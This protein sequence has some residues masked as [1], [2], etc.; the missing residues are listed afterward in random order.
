M[1]R[2]QLFSIDFVI[3]VA[4]IAA[5][6]GLLMQSHEFAFR[7]Q[8]LLADAQ[9]NAAQS[10]AD[11]VVAGVELSAAPDYCTSFSNGSTDC[12]GFSCPKN[13]FVGKRLVLCVSGELVESAC[14]MEVRACN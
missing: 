1:N 8:A 3:A 4:V 2:A 14:V 9:S 12:Q 7:N 10:I 5:G 6:V 13:V 11:A